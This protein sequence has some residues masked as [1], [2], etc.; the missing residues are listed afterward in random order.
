MIP[1][2]LPVLSAVFAL[3]CLIA[4]PV[5]SAEFREG[6]TVWSK[7]HETALLTEPS[8]L[9]TIAAKVGF[10]E[11]LSIEEVSGAWLRV[12][13]DGET[14]TIPAICE[15]QGD[16]LRIC[17][18]LSAQARPTGFKSEADSGTLLVTYKKD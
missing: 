8:P 18:A 9:A 17:Y 14:A 6:Q 7:H 4:L 15:L 5:S 1:A 16:T 11:K 10:A 12:K 13:S 2:R 3:A